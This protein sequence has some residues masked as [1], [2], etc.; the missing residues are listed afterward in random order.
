MANRVVIAEGFACGRFQPPHL[1]HLRFLLTAKQRCEFL[2]IGIT[3]FNVRSLVECSEAGHRSVTL[4]NPLTF[5]ER[6]Q[7]ISAMLTEANISR[8]EFACIPFPIDEP[9]SLPDFLSIAIPCYVTITDDWSQ[10]KNSRLLNA[11][12]TIEELYDNTNKSVEGKLIRASMLRGD[13]YWHQL[14][15]PV[16]KQKLLD[17]KLPERLAFLKTK[18]D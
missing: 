13:Q 4:D 5:F 8:A 17:V 3:Q 15:S 16:V 14:V 12:Y 11:G 10:E 6:V 18:A 9:D 7:L 2:W 1:D